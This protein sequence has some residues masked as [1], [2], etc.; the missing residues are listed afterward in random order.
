MKLLKRILNRLRCGKLH[1][2]IYTEK[3]VICKLW[4]RHHEDVFYVEK[5]EIVRV[6][7]EGINTEILLS[8]A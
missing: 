6:S 7:P 2:S 4:Y 3:E 1:L 5:I 8:K